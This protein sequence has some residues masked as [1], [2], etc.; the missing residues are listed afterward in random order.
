KTRITQKIDFLDDK[1]F[2][3]W[4]NNGLYARKDNE[5]L[6]S[7]DLGKIWKTLFSNLEGGMDIRIS[8]DGKIMAFSKEVL[9]SKVLGKDIYDDVPNTTAQIYTDL[10]YRHWDKW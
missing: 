10:D 1:S 2:I 6:N 8:P 4:D 9:L 5:L 7:A 3:Q